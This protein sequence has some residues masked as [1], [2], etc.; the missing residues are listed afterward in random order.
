MADDQRQE[1]RSQGHHSQL[2]G[3][4]PLFVTDNEGSQPGSAT[5][6]SRMRAAKPRKMEAIAVPPVTVRKSYVENAGDYTVDKVIRKLGHQGDSSAYK[7]KLRSGLQVE[8]SEL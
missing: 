8:V 6:S 2:A 3:T 7:V 5:R 4:D 1:L